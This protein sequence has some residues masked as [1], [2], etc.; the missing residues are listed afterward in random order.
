MPSEIFSAAS[1][2]SFQPDDKILSLYADSVKRQIE[3]FYKLVDEAIMRICS[4]YVTP[5]IKG[6]ITKT[7]LRWRGIK[8]LVYANLSE[9][10][11]REFV[12]IVQRDTL[13][14]P[15]G[16]K[17]KYSEYLNNRNIKQNDTQQD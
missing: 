16:T 14:F 17:M 10:C 8:T 7:K 12:G 4:K 11:G 13:I 9:G 15:N 5:P 6:E 2:D 1:L 3:D